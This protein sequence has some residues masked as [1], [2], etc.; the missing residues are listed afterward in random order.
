MRP[1]CGA[2][3]IGRLYVNKAQFI[4]MNAQL[5]EQLGLAKVAGSLSK[6]TEVMAIVN[7]LMRTPQL[8]Q[9]MQQMSREMMKARVCAFPPQPPPK[10]LPI[11]LFPMRVHLSWTAQFLPS[12]LPYSFPCLS[13]FLLL[14]WPCAT[15][16]LP[17]S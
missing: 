2:Q 12:W 6:S 11:C 16:L 17:C 9:T 14:L 4:S 15:G 5:T 8:M 13:P 3:T 7:D 10:R 1:S